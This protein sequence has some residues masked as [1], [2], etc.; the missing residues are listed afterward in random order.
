[1]TES[2]WWQHDALAVAAPGFIDADH[3]RLTATLGY[4]WPAAVCE[5]L[6]W[7]LLR[8]LDVLNV[9]GHAACS[10]GTGGESDHKSIMAE[11]FKPQ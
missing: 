4:S 11:L 7:M 2:N 9:D 8:G 6:D 10:I 3:L 1:M 5:K